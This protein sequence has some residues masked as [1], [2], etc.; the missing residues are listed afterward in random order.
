[1]DLLIAFAN[2]MK[3]AAKIHKARLDELLQ[4]GFEKPA[5]FWLAENMG[6]LLDAV[7]PC[8]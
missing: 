2:I 4:P 6:K 5:P 3:G 1:M 7:D 8:Y